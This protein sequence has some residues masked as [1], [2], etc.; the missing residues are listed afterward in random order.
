MRYQRLMFWTIASVR[1]HQNPV[2]GTGYLHIGEALHPATAGDCSTTYSPIVN[3][4][5][6]RNRK[7]QAFLEAGVRRRIQQGH[8]RSKHYASRWPG[9]WVAGL[10]RLMT[11]VVSAVVAKLPP[12]N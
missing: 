12:R 10:I 11:A 8:R 1:V 3:S 2:V 5:I 9:A 6:N 7:N 4:T